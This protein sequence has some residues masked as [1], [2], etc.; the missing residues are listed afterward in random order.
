MSSPTSRHGRPRSRPIPSPDQSAARPAVRTAE[1]A[2]LVALLRGGHRSPAE[3]AGLVERARSAISVLRQEGAEGGAQLNLLAEDPEPILRE[4]QAEIDRW[5]AAGIEVLT[6]LDAAYPQNLRQVHDRPPL[7]FVA[8][9]LEPSDE[10]AISVIG[11]RRASTDGLAAAGRIAAGMTEAGFTVVSGLAAGVDTA[12][13]TSA[14]RAQGRTVAVIGT[15]LTQS[16]PPEN[17][18]LQRQI[19]ERCAV[20]S[21]F[22]PETPASRQ[23]FP[24]RNAV[25]SGLTLATVIIEASV[26][27][28]AR[29]QAR[30]ALAHGRPVF[31]LRRLL[32]QDWAVELAVRPGVHVVDGPTQ[33]VDAVDRLHATDALVE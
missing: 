2:A 21:Q 24:M 20:V 10:R 5:A 15:G 33:I 6:V 29:V 7:L 22:W 13:H 12:A 8:G 28:G 1:T 17:A 18:G 30:Q 16:Y 3:Y 31:L 9:R 32:D 4:T 26:R 19:A 11:S 23:S 14:L 25:M 27:S